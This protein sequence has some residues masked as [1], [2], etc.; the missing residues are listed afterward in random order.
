MSIKKIAKEQPDTFEFSS[1]NVDVA[2][3]KVDVLSIFQVHGSFHEGR[4]AKHFLGRDFRRLHL[5]RF[6][7]LD[8]STNCVMAK[9]LLRN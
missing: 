9:F 7:Q 8:S 6:A 1:A 3:K 5:L 2:K 4:D